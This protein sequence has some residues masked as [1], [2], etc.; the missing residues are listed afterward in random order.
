PQL[1][2][3]RP[4]RRLLVRLHEGL[5]LRAARVGA[6]VGGG[7]ALHVEVVA[8]VHHHRE[9]AAERV[10]VH[11]AHAD[12]AQ[13][14]LHLRPDRAVMGLV[15]GDRARVVLEVQGEDVPLHLEGATFWRER[16]SPSMP[17]S[18]TSPTLRYTGSG[19]MPRPTPAGVPVLMTSPG[20]RDMNWLR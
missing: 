8:G 3:T 2:R 6:D 12:S 13:A 19:L 4:R 1:A 20:S 11:R 15:L 10:D 5:P 9:P 16:P 17:S 7:A 14:L 18:T